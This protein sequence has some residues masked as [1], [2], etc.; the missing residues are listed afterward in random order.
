MKYESIKKFFQ[1]R[2]GSENSTPERVTNRLV[3]WRTLSAAVVVSIS[4]AAG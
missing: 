3:V 2:R 4:A 1:T